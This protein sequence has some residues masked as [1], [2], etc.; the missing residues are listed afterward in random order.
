MSNEPRR[1]MYSTGVPNFRTERNPEQ[2]RSNRNS[3][4]LMPEGR[5]R[6]H[7][8][9]HGVTRNPDSGK[10]A[11]AVDVQ[12]KDGRHLTWFGAL[13]TEDRGNGSAWDITKRALRSMGWTGDDIREVVLDKPA[14]AT[15]AHE[16]F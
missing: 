10:L 5:H 9:E 15:I 2:Q 8:R 14:Y 1:Q 7:P 12:F 11:Y 3:R 6:I 16:E 4:V 13:T